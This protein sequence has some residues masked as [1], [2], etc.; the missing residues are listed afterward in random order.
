MN[1]REQILASIKKGILTPEEGLDLLEHLETKASATS[2]PETM[3]KMEQADDTAEKSTEA[4]FNEE[5]SMEEIQ[6]DKTTPE[7]KI[8]QQSDSVTD[9]IDAWEKDPLKSDTSD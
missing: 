7:E 4:V 2:A 3:I 6:V 5:P 1:Q 9:L 8:F